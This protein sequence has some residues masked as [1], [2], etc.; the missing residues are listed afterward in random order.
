MQFLA[1]LVLY[2]YSNSNAEIKS[3]KDYLAQSN[4]VPL[5]RT[6]I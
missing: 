4:E 5:A 6:K 1:L 2:N 3:K